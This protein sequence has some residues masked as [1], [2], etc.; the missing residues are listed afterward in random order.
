MPH[1]LIPRTPGGRLLGK[2]PAR[3]DPR[4]LAF[5][6]YASRLPAPPDRRSWADSE[7]VPGLG[8]LANDRL[9]DCAEAGALHQIQVWTARADGALGEFLPSDQDAIDAYSQV[10]GYNPADPATDQG[11]NMLDLLSCWQ[12]VGLSRR[13]IDAYT[14]VD[15]TNSLHVRQGIDLM[16][17][18]LIGLAL[19]ATVAA[20]E[21]PGSTWAVGAGPDAIPGSLGGHCVLLTG[22][23]PQ[24]LTAISWGAY[25]HLTWDFLQTYCDEAWALLSHDWI[26]ASGRSPSGFAFGML[27]ADLGMLA[28]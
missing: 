12:R 3:R 21:E 9:G 6:R 18:L 27:A 20:Q 4:S 2:A 26:A 5:A 19:P 8:M 16:G 23:G 24:E 28:A 1:A 13:R 22:Y 7:R 25:Y 15:P 10:T 14:A 11:T 17:G